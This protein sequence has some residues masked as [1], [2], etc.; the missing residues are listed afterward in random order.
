MNNIQERYQRQIIMPEIGEQG[1]Q[2]LSLAKVLVIGAGGL[3]CPVLLYLAA[4][5]VGTLGILDEDIVSLNNLHRQVLFSVEDIGLPKTSAAKTRIEKLNPELIIN[6]HQYRITNKNA[7][8]IIPG[9]DIIIDCTDN[10]PTRYMINDACV[11][12]K[13]PLVYGAISKFEGQVAV[14][15]FIDDQH[16]RSTNYRDIFPIPPAKNEIQNCNETGV[17]GVL[18]G[19][20]GTMMANETIK[21]I[22]GFGESLFNKMLVINL[23]NYQQYMINIVPGMEI[24]SGP[25][26]EEAFNNFNYEFVCATTA[27]SLLDKNSFLSMQHEKNVMLVDVREAGETPEVTKFVN[28][29]IPLSEIEMKLDEFIKD[30]IILF[31]QSGQRSAKAAGILSER[32]DHSKK[33]YSLEGGVQSLL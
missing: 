8:E 20:I 17:I 14:F 22:V 15:N 28:I 26:T 24:K 7:L 25:G 29:H 4:A 23:L 33:I 12:L 19:V 2:R 30:K 1:Q 11:L 13:K 21:M 5:G 3:G 27:V 10:F 31:C 6:E 9:Y 18:P 16:S 32:L